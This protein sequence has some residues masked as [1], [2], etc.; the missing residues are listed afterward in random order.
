MLKYKQIYDDFVSSVQNPTQNV[1]TT[2][3]DS[4]V[5]LAKLRAEKEEYYRRPFNSYRSEIDGLIGEV[6]GHQKGLTILCDQYYL[7]QK[8]EA[9]SKTRR[10]IAQIEES[11]KL[12]AAKITSEAS[13]RIS[14]VNADRD[15]EIEKVKAEL[16]QNLHHIE[17]DK[18]SRETADKVFGKSM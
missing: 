12:E 14:R 2:L 3:F 9:E 13:V 6:E 8:Q 4:W 18:L 1:C 16:T 5:V 10:Q 7:T 15:V 11:A 17:I